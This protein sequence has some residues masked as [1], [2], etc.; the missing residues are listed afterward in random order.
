MILFVLVPIG[1]NLVGPF[2]CT[3]RYSGCCVEYVSK[4]GSPSLSSN[5]FVLWSSSTT[6]RLPKKKPN[7]GSLLRA[8]LFLRPPSAPH[9]PLFL[10]SL[11]A[12]SE[13]GESG[14]DSIINSLL[15]V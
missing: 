4:N 10:S 1:V 9:P 6:T 14:R 7:I 13:V 3:K 8:S 12:F 15:K 2:S 5:L 11:L